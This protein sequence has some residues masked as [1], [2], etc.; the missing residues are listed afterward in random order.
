MGAQ[1]VKMVGLALVVIFGSAMD[2]AAIQ[3]DTPKARWPALPCPALQRL[4]P[5]LSLAVSC[6]VAWWRQQ[7]ASVC[8]GGVA[9]WLHMRCFLPLIHHITQLACPPLPGAE[10]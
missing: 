10:D 3:Q 7:P 4:L 5:C 6:A 9:W 8:P 1:V 2:I